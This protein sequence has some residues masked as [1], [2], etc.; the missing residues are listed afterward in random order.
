MPAN[1]DARLRGIDGAKA[2]RVV[3]AVTTETVREGCR[4]HELRGVEAVALGRG[5]TAGCLLATLTKR[6]DERLRLAVQ[7]SAAIRS[8][9][10]DA[11]GDGT[12]RGCLTSRLRAHVLPDNDQIGSFVGEG[13]LVVTRDLGLPN[14]YQGV[15]PLSS[16]EIDEDIERYLSGSEQLPS[17]LRCR[18]VLSSSGEVVAAAGVLCQTFPDADPEVLE[19]IRGVLL[20]LTD[21]LRQ[22]R[23]PRDL[24]GFALLGGDFEA[25][26]SSPLNYHCPCGRERARSVVST[27]GAEDLDQLATEQESTAVR[28]SY[29]GDVYTLTADDLRQLAEELRETRS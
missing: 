9:L 23:T 6:E 28:C 13:Q 1:K 25:M 15:V 7:G 21:L 5:L 12:V 3:T 26:V 22:P 4:R 20:G 16:G 14:P 29:C 10:V 11:R 2:I 18:V 27:L 19:P 24:M 17:V 8:M